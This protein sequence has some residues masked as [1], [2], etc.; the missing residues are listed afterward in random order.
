MHEA[1]ASR[2]RVHITS[3][4]PYQTRWKPSGIAPAIERFVLGYGTPLCYL[5]TPDGSVSSLARRKAA[6]LTT[7]F[8]K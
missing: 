6:T 1:G 7:G 8:S 5:A 2:I 3:Q 4:V